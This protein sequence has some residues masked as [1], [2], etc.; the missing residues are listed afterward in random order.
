MPSAAMSAPSPATHAPHLLIV[1]PR[2]LQIS[3]LHL[4]SLHSAHTAQPI[5][6]FQS[7]LQACD[8]LYQ[9]M[10]AEPATNWSLPLVNSALTH[11]RLTAY[12]AD[13]H[14]TTKQN[15]KP[16]HVIEAQDVLKRYLQKMVVD[17][18][19]STV[20][21]KRGC[22]FVICGLFQIYFRLN[23]L[24]MCTY[25][26]K[27]MK[28]L[29]PLSTYPMA[30]QVTYNYY[31]GRLLIFEENYTLAEAALH[32]ALVHCHAA[33]TANKRRILT[34]LI[35]VS[36]LRGKYPRVELLQ[37]Y[38]LQPIFQPLVAAIK[39]GDLARFMAELNDRAEIYIQKGIYLLL[40]KLK[41]IVYRNL[42]RL[43]YYH[44][45]LQQTNLSDKLRVQLSLPVILSAIRG[46]GVAMSMDELECVIANLIFNGAIKGY[47]AHGRCVV[48]SKQEPF[49]RVT[50]GQ[51]AGG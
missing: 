2:S 51:A 39:Q 14:R 18:S 20:N 49:P 31:Y 21:K 5:A 19:D 30:Q 42:L 22:L 11:L 8:L 33:H 27:M 25:L 3:F 24:K 40:E 15:D 13:T 45:H 16:R 47:I 34:F 37:K 43:V 29:P 32:D 23:N 7:S 48:L 26:M 44:V 35:P 4:R 6:A 17:R 41:I 38:D 9:Q 1:S 46:M 36:L 50:A 28:I 10:E 12:S